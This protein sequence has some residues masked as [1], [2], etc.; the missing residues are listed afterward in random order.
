MLQSDQ[1]KSEFLDL[2]NPPSYDEPKDAVHD[3]KRV[4]KYSANHPQKGSQAVS[5]ALDLP[6]GRIRSWVDGDGM[7]DCYRGLQTALSNGWIVDSW[8]EE[9]ARALNCLAAWILSSGGINENFVPT[10]VTGSEEEYEAL[11]GYAATAGIRLDQTR[12]P[13]DDRPPEW[14]P[15]TDASVLG[16]VLYTLLE[17][18]GD[19][20]REKV[21][22][23]EYLNEVPKPVLEDFL[24]VYVQQR[25]VYRD[26]RGEFIQI[27]TERTDGFRRA[28]K[29][30][31]QSVVNDP[32]EIR[33]DDWPIRIYGDAIE[34]LHQ[35]PEIENP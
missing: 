15:S 20:S 5:T 30:R 7:P 4:Q 24:Q 26:D 17:V 3:Y 23:P 35:Y 33:G 12:E 28:L 10:F 21:G 25:G 31:L 11:R 8:E 34:T 19:K 27:V 18:K 14:R 32:D 16:R 6:R 1:L 13:D 2:Y 22:F 29:S 9:T